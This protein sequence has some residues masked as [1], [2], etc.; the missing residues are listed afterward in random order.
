M[1]A[2][3]RQLHAET[4]HHTRRASGWNGIGSRPWA[5]Q[6][7]SRWAIFPDSCANLTYSGRVCQATPMV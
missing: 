7:R 6:E 3:E 1:T 2:Y 5:E 4:F